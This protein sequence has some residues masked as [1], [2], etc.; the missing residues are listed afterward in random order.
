MNKPIISVIIPVY[1]AVE[2][3]Q[4]CVDSLLSQTLESLEFIF[5]DD[6]SEDGSIEVLK[7]AQEK[8]VRIHVFQQENAGPSSAR[9]CGLHN[10]VGEYI[11]FCDSDDV[12]AK[13]WCEELLK[14]IREYPKAWINCGITFLDESGN[15][16]DSYSGE[17]KLMA[18]DQY[19]YVFSNGLSGS[20]CNKIFRADIVCQNNIVFD[21]TL[22]RG[23]D[24]LFNLSYLSVADSIY[25]IGRPL[26]YY[27]HY[28]S[29]DTLTN[30][31]HKDEFAFQRMLY[32]ARKPF[33]RND[34]LHSF[35]W[36]YWIVFS[37][38]L[39][40][41]IKLNTNDTWL[42]RI[43]LNQKCIEYPEYQELLHIFGK[44]EMHPLA[45]L[46]LVKKNY[47]GYKFIQYCSKIKR[48]IRKDNNT[49]VTSK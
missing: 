2:H 37:K 16:I 31:Y 42:K 3:L 5:V 35:N 4:R 7:S 29:L 9:N 13:D 21:E 10:A 19:W 32:L 18:K 20:L 23:E 47:Y 26:Y 39:D 12:V 36:H 40:D 24:V 11:M 27:Y 25:I 30:R 22:R 6:G 15:E 49:Q 14:T 33:I 34:D 38:T 17:E 48:Q 28:S 41:N 8:D 43:K 46:C 1:N 45:Y 44:N